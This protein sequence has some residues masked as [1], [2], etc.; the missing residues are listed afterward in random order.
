MNF[1]SDWPLI[2]GIGVMGVL[3]LSVIY[4]LIVL[5]NEG[6]NHQKTVRAIDKM[7]KPVKKFYP[8]FVGVDTDLSNAYVKTGPTAWVLMDVDKVQTLIRNGEMYDGRYD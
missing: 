7:R 3:F 8:M 4:R 5:T 6:E 2:L 1:I